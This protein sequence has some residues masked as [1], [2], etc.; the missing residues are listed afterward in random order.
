MKYLKDLNVVN[1]NILLRVDLNVPKKNNLIIDTSKIFLIKKTI[2]KLVKNK[3]KIFLLSHYGRPKNKNKLKFSLKTLVKDIEKIISL[4]KIHFIDDCIGKKIKNK[5]KFMEYGEICLLENVRFYKEEEQNDLEFSK[6]LALNFDLYINDAFSVS[7]RKHSSIVGV[8]KFLPSYGGDLLQKEIFAL[9]SILDKTKKPSMAIIGGFKISTK[10]HI[11]E[12]LVTKL[13]YLVIA[14]G[15]AN[16]FL[17]YQGCNLGSSFIEKNFFPQIKKIEKKAK[18]NSCKIILPIDVV[19]A[20]KIENPKKI[21]KCNLSQIKDDQLVLDIGEKSCKLICK[22][23]KDV[24]TILWNGPLGA[25]EYKPFNRSTN[26]VALYLSSLLRKINLTVVV[27]GGDTLA[28]MKK[29]NVIKNFTYASTSG[30]AFFEFLAGK[31]LPGIKSLKKNN[32]II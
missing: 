27:G 12:Y 30:G 8:T 26:T 17:A 23:F 11:L 22:L 18:I 2:K 25:F 4:G 13:D 32:L 20:S 16:T 15:M 14:G 1:K 19:T 7:H 3:N 10:I 6:K 29:I 5:I 9:K 21:V 28:S 24:N 31:E